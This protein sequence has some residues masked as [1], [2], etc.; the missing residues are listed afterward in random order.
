MSPNS[1]Q[2]APT[3][4]K[5]LGD[6][7]GDK[8]RAAVVELRAHATAQSPRAHESQIRDRTLA[9]RPSVSEI[10]NATCASGRYNRQAARGVGIKST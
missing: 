3:V 4:T 1:H 7:S 8:S 6:K 5:Y 2:R 9:R 10:L